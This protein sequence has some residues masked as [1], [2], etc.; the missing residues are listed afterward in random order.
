MDSLLLALIV[1]SAQLFVI[2]G[3]AALAEALGRVSDPTTK[4]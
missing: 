1:F 3:V 4:P 2:I